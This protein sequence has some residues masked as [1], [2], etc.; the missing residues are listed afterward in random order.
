MTELRAAPAV[1]RLSYLA[2]L[3]EPQ[4][5]E[6][7][8]DALRERIDTAWH[9][10]ENCCAY[11]LA[12]E[13]EVF[14][15]RGEPTDCARAA[16]GRWTMK[17]LECMMTRIPCALL[18]ALLASTAADAQLLR[19]PSR[20]EAVERH[21]PGDRTFTQWVHDPALVNTR[22]AIVS[23]CG[24]R[25]RGARDGQAH[26]PRAADP[27][28]SRRRGD[29]GRDGSRAAPHPRSGCATGATCGCTSWAMPTRSR[30]R[31]RWRPCSAT[32]RACRASAPARSPSSCRARSVCRPKPSRTSGP[33]ISNP[34]RRTRR[35]P[36]ARRTGASRS[37]SGTTRSSRARRSTRCSSRRSSAAS[38]S[39]ASKRSAGCGTSTATSGA[40]ACR[41]SSRRC[42]SATRPSRSRRPTSSR[43]AKPSPT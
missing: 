3:E 11:E 17:P 23:R 31:R 29:S 22:P 28:R 13:P 30:C 25:G 26:E 10:T 7:R 33:A 4:L 39:A 37:R 14:W 2:D 18:G 36:A 41:T 12:I 16:Q 40:R 5:V 42:A 38:R 15:R 9:A 27:V 34:S 24:G 32:T 43:S 6:Q 21:L 1:L 20:G 8:L 35:R 19:E